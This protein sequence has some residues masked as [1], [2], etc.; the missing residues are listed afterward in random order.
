MSVVRPFASVVL[1]TRVK[2][3]E[4]RYVNIQCAEN[5]ARYIEQHIEQQNTPN[6]AT[7]DDT[8]KNAPAKYQPYRIDHHKEPLES[9]EEKQAESMDDTAILSTVD[10]TGKPH[11][12]VIHF[13]VDKDE[14]FYFLSKSETKKIKNISNNPAVALTIHHSHSLKV[15]Y[16]KGTAEV[17]ADKEL[18]R[19]VYQ[20]V[21]KVNTYREGDKLAPVTKISAGEYIVIKIIPESSQY[22]DY[23]TDSW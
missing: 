13:E 17:V 3:Y 20:R 5:F 11:A 21:A 22:F 8:I 23:R 14:N 2:D 7:L 6:T 18:S 4:I 1:H 16:I 15:L 19:A 12:S 9:Q 10:E